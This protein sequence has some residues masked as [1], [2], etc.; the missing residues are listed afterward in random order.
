MILFLF[1][2]LK[3]FKKKMGDFD[4]FFETLPISGSRSKTFLSRLMF[5]VE[6]ERIRIDGC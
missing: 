6:I 1:I 4:N 3:G 2:Q 5:L